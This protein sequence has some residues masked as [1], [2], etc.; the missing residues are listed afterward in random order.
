VDEKV[1][2][3][4]NPA[5]M[6]EIPKRSLPAA[7]PEPA[8]NPEEVRP[9]A[10][11]AGGWRRQAQ[12]LQKEAHVFYFVFKHPRTRWYAKLLAVCTAG[13]LLSPVQLIP[14]FIPFIGFLDDI[15]VLFLGAKLLKRITPPDVLAE[16]RSLADAAE[17]RRKEEI[18]SKAAVVVSVVIAALWLLAAVAAS[19][20]LAKYIGK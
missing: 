20:L 11:T 14:S 13:Y 12:R 15:A 7:E 1:L 19:A 2:V 4:D 9:K 17:T 3:D 16:C 18:R 5:S 10:A 8:V 6:T